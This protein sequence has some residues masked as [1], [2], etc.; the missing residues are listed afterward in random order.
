MSIET[1]RNLSDVTDHPP[2]PL[3]STFTDKETKSLRDDQLCPG[4]HGPMVTQPGD[5]SSS[6][7]EGSAPKPGPGGAV[8]PGYVGYSAHKRPMILSRGL[9]SSSDFI[10]FPYACRHQ[11]LGCITAAS[12]TLAT[13]G[14]KWV[15]GKS[16]LSAGSNRTKVEREPCVLPSEAVRTG[17]PLQTTGLPS[18]PPGSQPSPAQPALSQ[19][20]PQNCPSAGRAALQ[21]KGWMATGFTTQINA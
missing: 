8:E 11:S 14:I 6:P 3:A 4:S 17:T 10:T 2:D 15:L 7:Q 13:L 21:G 1:G 19:T 9:G 18:T 16:E 12:W 20:S 5:R